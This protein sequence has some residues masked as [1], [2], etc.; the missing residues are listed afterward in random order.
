KAKKEETSY[1]PVHVLPQMNIGTTPS[2][3][4]ISSQLKP[5]NVDL[6]CATQKELS[7]LQELRKEVIEL[8]NNSPQTL[9]DRYQKRR[10]RA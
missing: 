10:L 1:R 2:K 3:L 7:E 9:K 6:L 4:V 5:E 8:T